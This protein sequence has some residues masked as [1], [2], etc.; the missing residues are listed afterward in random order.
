MSNDIV[1]TGTHGWLGSRLLYSI[2]HGLP[3]YPETMMPNSHVRC[4]YLK[5]E[6]ALDVELANGCKVS[7]IFG[8]LKNEQDCTRLFEGTQE[9][10]LLHTAG[11][12]HPALRVKEFFDNN[13][14]ATLNLLTAAAKRGCRR[15]VIVSSNSPIGCNPT[16]DHRFTEESPYNPYQG[17]G[18]S[19]KEMELRARERAEDLGIELVIIRPPWFYGPFQPPRQTLFFQMIKNGSG[20][21]VGDGTNQRSMI[22]VDNLCH[23]MNLAATHP[24]AAGNTY[25]IADAEP[26][27]MKTILD[28]IED[29]LEKDFGM[30]VAHKR[31]KLP[32]IA[33][34]IAYVADAMIQGAGFYHQKIHVLS[35]M[36]K[37][38]ACSVD[39]AQREL[40]YNPKISLREGMR[41]SI[42]WCLEQ[43]MTI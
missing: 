38:I 10:L 3:D 23:G 11:V 25:W 32:G 33:A 35:E 5:N 37:N 29:V 4:F 26:Y 28:T 43:G 9:P 27:E 18:R 24:A 15:A 21:L 22:Y 7:N 20:P 1:L 6:P 36:N 12:I 34:D 40:G 41:R 2:I 13:V 30:D 14:G 39:K 31:M 8:D 17:Y 19:K 42:E 16:P